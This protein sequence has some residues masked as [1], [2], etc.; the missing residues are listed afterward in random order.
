MM[1]MMKGEFIH[2][3]YLVTCLVLFEVEQFS[4][5]YFM[6]I[7]HFDRG[8]IFFSFFLLINDCGILAKLLSVC[9]ILDFVVSTKARAG[10]C[11]EGNETV[12]SWF[13]AS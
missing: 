11:Y 13:N 7:L 3:D 9:V 1:M 10:K 4:T 8:G 5:S 2:R 12:V 6:F